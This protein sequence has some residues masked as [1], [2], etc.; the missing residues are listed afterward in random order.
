MIR[1]AL[2]GG[3]SAEIDP[4]GAT[5]VALRVP[6]AAGRA[7]DVLA[8]VPDPRAG[9]GFFGV[10]VGRFANRIAGARF[11]L[12]G[13]THRLSANDGANTLHGGAEGFDRRDWTVA[14]H[15]ARSVTLELVSP[16]GDQGF[17]GRLAA[18][19]TYEL[20]DNSAAGNSSD[21]RLAI[22]MTATADR[23]TP[24]SLT[25]HAFFNLG[26][27]DDPAAIR[28]VDDHRL[29]IAAARYLPVDDAA[30]PLAD[31]PQPV[32]GTPFDF[33]GG[34]RIGDG[35]RS[36]HPQLL[37][38]RGYD[39]CFALDGAGFRQAARLDHPAS[40]RGMALW[41]DAPGLQLYTGNVLDGTVTGKGGA[42][43][44]MG[45]A[46]CLEPGAWPDSPNR[47]D[48]PGC[49]LRPGGEYRHRMALEFSAVAPD[50]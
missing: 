12:D 8:G 48:F 31:A 1:L 44:R 35:L 49:I 43:Y 5:L 45:D 47:P 3:L 9:R 30:I 28:A 17:P 42:A 34:R 36:G 40:G 4:F 2:P 13:V 24:V 33:R 22:T 41:T 29:T 20:Q 39:H 25:N 6:D 15:D 7:A 46:V 37:R 18:R 27:V 19:V 16:D 14:A 21:G 10:T 11:D 50:R 38:G 26:G 32:A 23:A